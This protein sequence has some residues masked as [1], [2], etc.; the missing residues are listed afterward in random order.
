MDDTLLREQLRQSEERN[1]T[2]LRE[3]AS[4]QATLDQVVKEFGA[5]RRDYEALV[6]ATRIITDERNA[7]RQRVAE[8]EAANNRLT[9]MLWG[10]RSERR[11]ESPD[12]QHLDF[13]DGPEPPSAEEQE[14]ITA[15]A[16]ADEARDRELLKRLEARRKARREQAQG[17]EEFPPSIERRERV[18]DLP[19]DQKQGLTPIG[20]KTTER[21]RFE[22]PHIYVEVIKRPQYVVAG[23]PEKGVQSVPPPLSIVE[24][25]KYD[26]SVVAAIAALKFAFHVPTYRQQ[27]WFAQSGWFPSRSTVNDLMNYAVETIGPLYQQMWQLLLAQPMLLVSWFTVNWNSWRSESADVGTWVS[28]VDGCAIIA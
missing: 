22:K 16:E 2:L 1:A 23:Q 11:R 5:F 8:L 19:E 13:G 25:C 24:G 21:L 12:Q 18:L 27:D 7:F 17:R 20:V 28:S 6:D 4:L 3:M 26:F 15:Q 9:D 14:I 10:R